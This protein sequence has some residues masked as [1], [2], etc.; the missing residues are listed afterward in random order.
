[1]NKDFHIKKLINVRY[2]R[3][4]GKQFLARCTTP[5]TGE[6][7]P[8]RWI[9][10]KELKPDLQ[11]H[12]DGFNRRFKKRRQPPN[13]VLSSTESDLADEE[14]PRLRK[15]K[16][17]RKSGA[18]SITMMQTRKKQNLTK[19]KFD[20]KTV[21]NNKRMDNHDIL[22]EILLNTANLKAPKEDDDTLLFEISSIGTTI[23]SS[24]LMAELIE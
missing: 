11:W 12:I 15:K 22:R 9:S 16:T 1:M 7:L 19:D 2:G 18:D 14:I 23:A 17:T 5:I 3:R 8:N 13:L 6:K 20:D 24:E 4:N 21:M 10:E